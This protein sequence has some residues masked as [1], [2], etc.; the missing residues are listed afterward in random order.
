VI[1]RLDEE[2]GK[3]APLT[4]TRGKVHQYL[5]MTIDYSTSGKV[6]ILMVDYIEDMLAEL[7]TAMDGEAATAAGNHLFEVNEKDATIL[8][9]SKANMF[10]HNVAKMLLR[11]RCCS[12][13]SG[14]DPTSKQQ[15]LSYVPG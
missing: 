15:W 7:P 6:K 13:A 9:K 4:K 5:G 1:Q 10:H 14:Q 11:P 2:F 12:Y 8:H 3:E